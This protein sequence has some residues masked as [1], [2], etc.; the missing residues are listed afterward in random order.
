[1]KYDWMFLISC[2]IGFIGGWNLLNHIL[3]GTILIGICFLILFIKWNLQD[4]I[5]EAEE[6]RK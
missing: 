1:M 4:S 5:R 3:Q 2:L 6:V